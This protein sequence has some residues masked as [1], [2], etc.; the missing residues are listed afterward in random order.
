MVVIGLLGSTLDR[1]SDADRWNAWRPTV[2]ICRQDDLV[3]HRFELLHTRNERKLADTVSAD[4]RSVSPET[5]VRGHVVE[6]GDPWDF[7]RVYEAL[8]QFAQGY[9]FDLEHEDYLVHVTTGTH[10][11]QI[12]LF[13][14]TETRL[15]RRD[16]CKAR[17]RGGA[18]RR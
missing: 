5:T 14:L 11:A 16:C 3:V 4:I 6:F 17:R 12:C 2:D 9:P 1:G 7:G 10:V 18:R 13:L 15:C 8:L